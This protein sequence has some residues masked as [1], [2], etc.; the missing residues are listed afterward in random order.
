M[1]PDYGL[2]VQAKR[3]EHELVK[4]MEEFQAEKRKRAT[5]FRKEVID[6][7]ERSRKNP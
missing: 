1:V 2:N 5:N 3:F 6:E 7:C 4:S